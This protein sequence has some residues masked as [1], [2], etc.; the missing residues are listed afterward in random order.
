MWIC[1]NYKVDWTAVAA[2][3]ALWIWAHDTLR[4]RR[5]RAA[6]RRLLA[7]MMTKPFMEAEGEIAL[8]RT[9]LVATFGNQASSQELANAT[10]AAR[11]QF[12]SKASRV[13]LDLPNQFIEKAD[14]FDPSSSGRVANAFAQIGY[15]HRLWKL[16]SEPHEDMD[17]DGMLLVGAAAF[18]QVT[19]TE[20]AIKDALGAMLKAGRLPWWLRIFKEKTPPP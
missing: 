9:S 15:L 17:S 20:E 8:F 18:K 12:H 4:R 11:E 19:I 2:A 5:E 10:V 13:K 7:Q 1:T 14:L 6:S 16:M 3:I